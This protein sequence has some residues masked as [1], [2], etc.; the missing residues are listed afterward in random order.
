[1]RQ[2][3]S[4][5]EGFQYFSLLFYLSYGV[6]IKVRVLL[7]NVATQVSRQS[8]RKPSATQSGYRLLIR[9]LETKKRPSYGRSFQQ[10]AC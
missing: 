1:M 4:L 2:G 3:L 9:C 8:V 10:P 7:R 6:L 5:L